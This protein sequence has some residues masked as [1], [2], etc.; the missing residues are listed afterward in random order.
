MA[1]TLLK[2]IKRIAKGNFILQF[3]KWC[4]FLAVNDDGGAALGD[5][6]EGLQ[7]GSIGQIAQDH[8]HF[9]GDKLDGLV[10][11]QNQ[12][13]DLAAFFQQLHADIGAKETGGTGQQIIT[14]V[15][16]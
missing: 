10:I 16:H 11:G 15:V 5:G 13:P 3:H 12:S 1:K 6:E 9:L 7:G 4:Q 2:P 8:F 14:F